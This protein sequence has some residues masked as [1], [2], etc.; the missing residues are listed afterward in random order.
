[1]AAFA[2]HLATLFTSLQAH[3]AVFFSIFFLLHP[4]VNSIHFQLNRFDPS[5]TDIVYEGDAVPSVGAIEF[6]KVNY[7]NRKN[8]GHGLVFFL[9]P[10]DFD[11]PPNSGGGFLGLFNTTTSDSPKN[12]I[13]TVEFDSFVNPEWDRSYEHVGINNNSISSAVNTPWNASLHSGDTANVWITYNATTQNLSVFWSYDATSTPPLNSSLSYRIDLREAVSEWVK[14]GFSAATSQYVERHTLESWEFSSTLDTPEASGNTT[15]RNRV[16][17]GVTVPVCTLV[18]MAIIAS[19]VSW[20]RKHTNREATTERNNTTSINYDLERGAGP[21]R[22]SYKDLSSATSNFSSER[23]LGQGG[24]GEVYKGCLNDLDMAVAVKKISRGSK[25]GRKE[26]ITEVKIIS[27]LRHRN[28]V[29]LVGWCHD[30]GEF[31]LVYEFMPNGSLDN[32]LFSKNRSP[33]TWAVR[34]KISLGLASALLYLHEEWEQCVVHRDIKSS[35]VMLDSS[36][37]VKLGDFG[38]ARFMDHEVGPQTTGL[39]GTFGYMAPEYISTGKASKESDVYSFGVVALE[40]ATGRKSLD[41]LEGDSQIGLVEWVWD[42]YG[43]EQL[44]SCVDERLHTN[45]DA[46]QVEC[47]MIVGLWCAHPDRSLRPS[48][49]QAMHVLNFEAAMPS[50]PTKM[51]VPV[52]HAPSASTS[53]GEPSIT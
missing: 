11:I 34:Y 12:Q 17:V 47:L 20:K 1:M 18:L 46:K 14:V 32:H 3:P 29:Q 44:Q 16:I 28:L 48:I 23:K 39:A 49:R 13:V 45:F 24:F 9:A 51:P 2:Y 37:N 52:Y 15:K 10:L 35:N 41:P 50:L 43:K 40:I 7:I 19:I 38:L 21:R 6:N 5:A 33:V 42:L 27:R 22:Y 26:Y 31:L 8:Y 53:S 30:R 4:S 36:F 25:Q